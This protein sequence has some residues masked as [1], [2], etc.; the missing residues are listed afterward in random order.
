MR[1]MIR[2]RKAGT[3][4]PLLTAAALLGGCGTDSVSFEGKV[5][6]WAGI[7]D[8]AKA[9]QNKEPK[10]DKRAPLAM[11]PT[12]AKLPEPGTQQANAAPENWPD[13][14]DV[15]RKRELAETKKKLEEYRRHGDFS[16]RTGMEEFRRI[17]DPL[18]RRP[19]LVADDSKGID[20][21]SADDEASPDITEDI[22]DN[23][24]FKKLKKA[25]GEASS[26][27]KEA[28]R[29]NS[30]R[31]SKEELKRQE[32]QHNDSPDITDNFGSRW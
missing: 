22:K 16:D 7:S 15:R 25:T 3:L 11:P 24:E 9:K 21:G 26:D 31:V 2:Y 10:L 14:P 30:W 8:K 20:L 5:F 13:D 17:V 28:A 32:K 19:G 4:I 12:A 6:D 18:E 29:Q 27:P 1:S 23:V